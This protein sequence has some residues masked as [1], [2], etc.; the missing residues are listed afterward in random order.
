M[1]TD[2]LTN[3]VAQF[4]ANTWL[5]LAAVILAVMYLLLA[6]RQN[7]ACWFAAILST[8]IYLH[9]FRQVNLYMESAL[10]VYYMAMAVYGWWH[11][12]QAEGTAP[13]PVSTRPWRWH[14][15]VIIAIGSA[16][17][18][19]GKLLGTF[20][21]D[22][23]DRIAAHLIY[24]DSFTTWASVVTTFMVA[25]KIL[26]NWVYW[27]VIDS[28]SIYLY[29]ERGLYFTVLLFVIYIVIIFFGWFAWRKT[30]VQHS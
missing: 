12:R 1:S 23:T 8:I 29:L 19:S 28:V 11:W 4:Q 7:I 15:A 18:V 3:F 30:L 10:Q 25:R 17:L 24:I 9:V 22:Q 5:E 20:F 2:A 16:T 13:L 21:Y 6:V 27:L 14:L 26:E